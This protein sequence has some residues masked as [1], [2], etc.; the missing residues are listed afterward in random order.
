MIKY[1]YK[2]VLRKDHQL[3]DG[4]Y[5]VMLQAFLGGHRVRIRLDLYL[6]AAEWDEK[7]QI[8]RIQ[9]DREKEGRVNAILAKHRSRV[10]GLFFEA[11]MSGQALSASA[12]LEEFDN[13]P[14]MESLVAFITREI[15]RERADKEESTVKQYNSTLMHLKGFQEAATFAD[16]SFDFVQRFDR[17]LRKKGIGD[18]ARAKY[19]TVFRKFILLAQKKRRRVGNPYEEFKIRSVPVERVWLN[20]EEVDTLVQLYRAGT[21]GSQL[22]RTLRHFL[23]QIVTSVRVSDLHLLVRSDIEGDLMVFSPQKTKRQRKLVKIPLSDLAKQLIADGEGSGENLFD[24]PADASAN[25]RL[26]EIAIISGIKKR[27]TTHVGRHTFGFLYLL[28][29]GKIE[30]LREIMGH[31]KLETTQIYTHTDH[32]R[33]VAGVRKFDQVFKVLK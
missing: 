33:K 5:P 3:L 4:T 19:H 7:K 20:V 1:T 31:S 11:R 16:I 10:E 25:L 2:F 32:D 15:E 6:Q 18:N 12:F 27:L 8:A 9:K 30:E 13:K 14:A 23:F 29:G 28:M 26:K 22:Q 21:L 17:Y 24:V